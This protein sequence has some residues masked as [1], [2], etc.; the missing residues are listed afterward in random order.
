[1]ILTKMDGSARGG[2]ILAVR[3]ELGVP[4]R[5]VGVGERADDLRPFRAEAFADGLLRSEG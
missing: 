2:V 5:F 1:V 3:E 4:V